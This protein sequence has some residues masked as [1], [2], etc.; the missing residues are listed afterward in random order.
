MFATY[1]LNIRRLLTQSIRRRPNLHVKSEHRRIIAEYSLAVRENCSLQ[2]IFF[3]RGQCIFFRKGHY[4]ISS[5]KQC[6]PGAKNIK[7]IFL[8]EITRP[9]CLGIMFV[10][11]SCEPLPKLFKLYLWLPKMARPRMPHFIC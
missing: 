2:C 1:S 4:Q 5:I 9:R 8:S 3:R 7:K 6:P 10:A 11:A